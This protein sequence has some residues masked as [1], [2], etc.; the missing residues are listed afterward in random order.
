[1]TRPKSW[2]HQL[3]ASGLSS[4]SQL[5]TPEKEK[6]VFEKSVSYETLFVPSL[7]VFLVTVWL[8]VSKHLI[9]LPYHPS[10]LVFP[11]R[12]TAVNKFFF[13][14]LFSCAFDMCPPVSCL[15]ACSVWCTHADIC[16]FTY[17]TF[18]VPWKRCVFYIQLLLCYTRGKSLK[19]DVVCVHLSEVCLSVT[20]ICDLNVPIFLL[21]RVLSVC[22]LKLLESC[23]D[24]FCQLLLFAGCFEHFKRCI[25]CATVAFIGFGPSTTPVVNDGVDNGKLFE[26]DSIVFF[27]PSLT[28]F[29]L[30]FLRISKRMS[31]FCQLLLWAKRFECLESCI[32]G[33]VVI[34]PYLSCSAL[35]GDM[36]DEDGLFTPVLENM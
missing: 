11:V 28:T 4:A 27:T 10:S 19:S 5:R 36:I 32:D 1:M 14:V 6:D 20:C 31:Y 22:C 23:L 18:F 35:M 24:L 25:M 15:N 21:Y 29:D 12:A 33:V 9:D 2:A 16:V 7:V 30:Y 17:R 8:T 34:C 26:L 13:C 3:A